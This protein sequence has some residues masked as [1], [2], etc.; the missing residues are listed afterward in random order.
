MI[1]SVVATVVGWRFV[2][3][4]PSFDVPSYEIE[5]LG[6]L[7]AYAVLGFLAAFVA[8]AFVKT[9]V[10]TEG[11]FDG[12]KIHPFKKAIIGGGLLGLI[13][14]FIPHVLGSGEHTIVE[15]LKGISPLKILLLLVF[16]KIVAVSLTLA[17]GGSGGVF[18]PSLFIGAMLGGVVG[19]IVNALFP[20]QTAGPGAYA[21][22]GMGAVLAAATHAPIT[23]ILIIFEMTNEYRIILPLMVSCILS[24]LLA[25]RMSKASIYTVDL[26]R[27]GID[28]H[29]GRDINILR[30]LSVKDVMRQDFQ[31]VQPGE[32]LMPIVTRFIE[33]QGSSIFVVDFN[34]N[35]KGVITINEIRPMLADAVSFEALLIAQDMMQTSDFPTVNPD[36]NLD[37]VMKRLSRH[38]HEVAVIENERIIG[39]IWPE[40]VIKQYNTE[41][42]KQDMAHGMVTAV[43]QEVDYETVT[44]IE[45]MSIVEIQ[46]PASFYGKSLL[47]L[48]L[49]TEYDVS[50]L[51]IKRTSELMQ[52]EIER[53]NASTVFQNG[54]R[55]LV[56]GPNK[57]LRRLESRG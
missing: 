10:F 2:S 17:A 27:K 13:A 1:S 8:L 11:F 22:V 36:D 55:M 41:L 7:G 30:R 3:E 18:A 51:L 35:L 28:I 39:V 52:E 14:L 50:V 57:S 53:P 4:H 20:G 15:A 16:F 12:W 32:R 42:F 48:K 19:N 44:G 54:D 23:A 49:G 21:L 9:L 26:L 6:E 56:M 46:V 37:D 31:T 40:D 5:H 38:R 29:E 43:N 47:E 24:T 34:Q 45:G 33:N 25:M